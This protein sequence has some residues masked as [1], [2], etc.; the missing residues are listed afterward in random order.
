MGYF[1][2]FFFFPEVQIQFSLLRAASESTA[3]DRGAGLH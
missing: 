2:L 1:T 3:P